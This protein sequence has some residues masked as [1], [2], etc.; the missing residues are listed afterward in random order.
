MLNYIKFVLN[1]NFSL[2]CTKIN[3]NIFF[4]LI[5][6]CF[7]NKYYKNWNKI[8]KLNIYFNYL[9]LQILTAVQFMNK[10]LLYIYSFLYLIEKPDQ[11]I[12]NNNNSI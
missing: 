2:F 9:L 8:T 7:N 4:H 11:L 3:K 5:E 1:F 6:I 12:Q 10:I